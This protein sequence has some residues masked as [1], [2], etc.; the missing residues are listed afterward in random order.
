[1]KKENHCTGEEGSFLG[2]VSSLNQKILAK[3]FGI[4]LEWYSFLFK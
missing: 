4:S 3:S 2:F 1:M